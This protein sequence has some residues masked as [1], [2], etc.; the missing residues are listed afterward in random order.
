MKRARGFTLIEMMVVVGIIG[1]LA[2]L[3][4]AA[5]G[6]IG[7]QSAPQNAVHDFYSALQKARSTAMGRNSQVWVVI[8]PNVAPDGTAGNGAWFLLEDRAGNFGSTNP[9][10]AYRYGTFHPVTAYQPPTNDVLLMDSARLNSYP[11]SNARF[12]AMAAG[13]VNP[14]TFRAPFDPLNTISDPQVRTCS[15]C[16]GTGVARRGAMIFEG[17]GSVRFVDAT[18]APA[19]PPVATTFTASRTHAL[20][21]SDRLGTQRGYLIAISG[22]TGFIGFNQ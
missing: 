14:P 19:A 7:E 20:A 13:A 5:Y 18:G 1:I 4:V 3:S 17:D 6:R 15:F 16:S 21:L 11:R 12:G 2:G 10:I 22:T 8:Y 9:A